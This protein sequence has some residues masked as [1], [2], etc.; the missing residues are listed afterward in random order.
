MTDTK[1][2]ELHV[3]VNLLQQQLK[4]PVDE[5][6]KASSKPKLSLD[7]QNKNVRFMILFLFFFVNLLGILYDVLTS[8]CC[9]PYIRS[10]DFTGSSE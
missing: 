7:D 1:L 8:R 5:S 10:F 9:C 4:P 6:K 3:D 2:G